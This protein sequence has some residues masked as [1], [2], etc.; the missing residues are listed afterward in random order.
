VRDPIRHR[1]LPQDTSARLDKDH[2]SEVN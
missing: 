2:I 1:G